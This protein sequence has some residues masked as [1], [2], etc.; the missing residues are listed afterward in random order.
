MLTPRNKQGPSLCLVNDHNLRPAAM[1]WCCSAVDKQYSSA[2]ILNVQTWFAGQELEGLESY[3]WAR[4]L[5]REVL[6][7][8]DYFHYIH[9][10]P[11]DGFLYGSSGYHDEGPHRWERGSWRDRWD[12]AEDPWSLCAGKEPYSSLSLT[13]EEEL[14]PRHV[15]AFRNRMSMNHHRHPDRGSCCKMFVPYRHAP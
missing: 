12:S 11:H 6:H 13:M 1:D 4:C 5:I 14:Q 8:A 2:T 7:Q 15:E 3:C 9:Y 10:D